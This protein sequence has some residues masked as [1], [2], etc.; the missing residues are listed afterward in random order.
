MSFDAWDRE[1]WPVTAV[2]VV[3]HGERNEPEIVAVSR[4]EML[5]HLIRS[6]LSRRRDDVCAFMRSAIALVA[7]PTLRLAHSRAA[8]GRGLRSIDALSARLGA[9]K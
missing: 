1:W 6:M 7:L 5:A 8:P 4:E 2:T 3:A 9:A